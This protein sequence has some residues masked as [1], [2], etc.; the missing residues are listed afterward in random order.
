MDKWNSAKI[1]AFN[2]WFYLFA[3]KLKAVTEKRWIVSEYV[4]Y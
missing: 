3:D 4:C 2:L 1:E